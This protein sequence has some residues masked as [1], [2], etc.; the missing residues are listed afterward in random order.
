[1]RQPGACTSMDASS[2][3]KF[4][5]FGENWYVI[6]GEYEVRPNGGGVRTRA[7]GWAR[8]SSGQ[9]YWRHQWLAGANGRSGV[10]AR[11]AWRRLR[12]R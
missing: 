8:G 5:T 1:M 11:R 4:A 12:R 7:K 2:R 3:A 10:G 6:A 9:G